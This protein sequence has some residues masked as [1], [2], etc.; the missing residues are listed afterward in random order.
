MKSFLSTLVVGGLVFAFGLTANAQGKKIGM[1]RAQT[2]AM[3]RAKGLKLKAKELENEKG[4]WIYSFEFKNQD[5]STREVNVDA[6]SGAVIGV[7]HESKSQDAK[8][9]RDEKKGKN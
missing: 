7:E 5:G 2:I 3:E 6:F 4:K 9:A 8:E 1:K